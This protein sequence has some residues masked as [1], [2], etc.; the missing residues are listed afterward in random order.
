MMAAQATA[1]SSMLACMLRAARLTSRPMISGN[2]AEIM[3]RLAAMTVI[4]VRKSSGMRSGPG[5]VGY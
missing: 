3:N 4:R 1:C 2:A 5:P